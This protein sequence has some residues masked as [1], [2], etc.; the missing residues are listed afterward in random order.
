MITTI[1][2]VRAVGNV[3]S[4]DVEE[5]NIT[6]HFIP[7]SAAVIRIIGVDLYNEIAALTQADERRKQVS[8][9]EACFVLV[10]AL[11]ALNNQFGAQGGVKASTSHEGAAGTQATTRNLTPVEV[12]RAVKQFEET[13]RNIL[14]SISE[15][16]PPCLWAKVT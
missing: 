8:Y 11:P 6:P 15:D 7:A 9:A 1:N 5:Q 4:K 3:A 2:E 10:Y 14:K 12:Q 16:S 13:A